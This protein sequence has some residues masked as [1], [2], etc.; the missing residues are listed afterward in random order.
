MRAGVAV[1]SNV[2]LTAVFVERKSVQLSLVNGQWPE[3]MDMTSRPRWTREGGALW[4]GE[5]RGHARPG[6]VGAQLERLR[7]QMENGGGGGPDSTAAAVGQM[8][9]R[10]EA[11]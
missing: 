3:E 10:A 4:R 8:V 1:S 7:I 11:S 5:R 9:A 2:R 6:L